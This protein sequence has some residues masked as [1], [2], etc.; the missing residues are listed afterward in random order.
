MVDSESM[1]GIKAGDSGVVNWYLNAKFTHTWCVR[2][3]VAYSHI[4]PGFTGKVSSLTHFNLEPG[5]KDY[6]FLDKAV[7]EFEQGF[8][9]ILIDSMKTPKLDTSLDMTDAITSSVSSG[10]LYI[11]STIS[12]NYELQ[13]AL[14]IRSH[15]LWCQARDLLAPVSLATQDVSI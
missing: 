8:E 9:S 2:Q 5:C 4:Y 1:V 7:V 11:V 6:S 15:K 12:D 3:F 14:S 13:L 10:F